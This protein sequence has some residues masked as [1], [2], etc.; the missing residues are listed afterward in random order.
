MEYLIAHAERLRVAIK[1]REK[2]IDNPV[3]TT[4]ILNELEFFIENIKED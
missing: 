3:L 1:W 4:S 2:E